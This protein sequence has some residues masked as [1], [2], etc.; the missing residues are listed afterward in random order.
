[1]TGDGTVRSGH[2][3][4]DV[5]AAILE[6]SRREP[7]ACKMGM[8]CLEVAPGRC[9]VEMAVTPDMVNLFG[10]AHGGA[11]FSLV[12]E[13]FQIAANA[14][15]VVAYALNL[16]VTYVSASVPG[17]VLVAE[18]REIAVTRRTSTYEVRV[19]RQSGDLVAVAQ[20]LAYRK[21]GPSPFPG[22]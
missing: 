10:T 20:A 14:G 13:A 12:D 21:G 22:P 11:V 6:A 7:Y 8:R 18:G 3:A 16:S 19:V 2:E 9:R 17:D 15:G 4:K 5:S 1:M